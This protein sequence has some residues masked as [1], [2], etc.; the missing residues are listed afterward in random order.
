MS[1]FVVSYPKTGRSRIRY[2]LSVYKTNNRINFTHDGFGWL[3]DREFNFNPKVRTDLY[4]G[5]R[6]LLL[7]RDPKDTLVSLYFQQ[8][9]RNP[10]FKGT[11]GEFIR[12]RQ[13]AVTM[14]RFYGMWAQAFCTDVHML[15]FYEDFSA[16]PRVEFYRVVSFFNLEKNFERLLKAVKMGSFENMKQLEKSGKYPQRWLQPRNKNDNDS[17]KCRRGV[18]GGYRDYLDKKDIRYI[19]RIIKS[20]IILK[21]YV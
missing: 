12:S 15:S 4:G 20:N 14:E 9:K 21:R 16:A 10:F 6:V 8:T 2:M 3:H 19:N 1:G 11:M 7:A 13:G 18:I 17:Y 5:Q